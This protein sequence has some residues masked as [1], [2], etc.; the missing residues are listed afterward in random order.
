MPGCVTPRTGLQPIAVLAKPTG[1]VRRW[2]YV[3]HN[4]TWKHVVLGL[5]LAYVAVA[6]IM[7]AVTHHPPTLNPVRIASDVDCMGGSGNG[8]GYVQ[9]P[10]YVGSSDPN[11]LD[12][13]GNGWGCE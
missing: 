10:V 12:G 9:G 6:L 11:G 8:P 5:V 2:N 3:N 7:G 4:I 13:D 1:P